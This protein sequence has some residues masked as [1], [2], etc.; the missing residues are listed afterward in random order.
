M[1]KAKGHRGF[2][3]IVIRFAF[4]LFCSFIVLFAVSFIGSLVLSRIKNPTAYIGIVSLI[5][6]LI[7]AAISGI[8]TKMLS[9]SE[10]IIYPYLVAAAVVIIEM[11]ISLIVCK[12]I[13]LSALMNYGCYIGVY[14]LSAFVSQKRRVRKHRR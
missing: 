4:Y 13:P 14:T 2:W 1:L 6:I 8:M 10:G 12:K 7:S 11:A 5:S 9:A 3:E